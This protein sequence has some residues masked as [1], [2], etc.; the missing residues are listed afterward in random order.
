MQFYEMQFGFA[1]LDCTVIQK[2]QNIQFRNAGDFG[3]VRKFWIQLLFPTIHFLIAQI[4]SKLLEAFI[5]PKFSWGLRPSM[6]SKFRT[7][8]FQ[9][10]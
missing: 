5:F 6:I 3:F 8:T 1:A 2:Y 9:L 4:A 10:C 7:L